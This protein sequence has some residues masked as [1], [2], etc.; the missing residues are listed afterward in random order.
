M[1]LIWTENAW[2]EYCEWQKGDQKYLDRVNLLLN[3][4]QRNCYKGIG[5]PEPLRGK[6]SGWWSRRIDESNR[7]V[8]RKFDEKS[9]IISSCKTHYHEK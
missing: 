4:I 8:Y 3:D 1:W 2:N 7:I 6:L 5:K 9:V